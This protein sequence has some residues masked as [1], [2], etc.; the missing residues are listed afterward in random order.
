MNCVTLCTYYL[1]FHQTAP[2][3]LPFIDLVF[4]TSSH[5]QPHKSCQIRASAKCQ[6][7]KSKP[8]L[9]TMITTWCTVPIH[10]LC[11]LNFWSA[12][13]LPLSSPLSE[14]DVYLY[15]QFLAFSSK[16]ACDLRFN[17]THIG[18]FWNWFSLKCHH[19]CI[20]SIFA[21]QMQVHDF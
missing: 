21:M 2:P 3:L 1:Y 16:Q 7:C 14:K 5:S 4:S 15:P 9:S 19:S 11:C 20:K 6:N 10:L 17:C 8:P 18:T 13:W 12:Y